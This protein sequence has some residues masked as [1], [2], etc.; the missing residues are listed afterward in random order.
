MP[1][2]TKKNRSVSLVWLLKKK[3]KKKPQI[4]E[5]KKVKCGQGLTIA[6]HFEQLTSRRKNQGSFKLIRLALTGK[7]HILN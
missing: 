3:K 6:R 1:P 2:G 4:S 7:C 5:L